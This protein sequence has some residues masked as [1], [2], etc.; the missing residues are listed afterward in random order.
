MVSLPSDKEKQ[1]L[2]TSNVSGVCGTMGRQRFRHYL[3]CS[4]EQL[5]GPEYYQDACVYVSLGKLKC[6]DVGDLLAERQQS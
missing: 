1:A 2:V 4:S 6:T 3:I 5:N